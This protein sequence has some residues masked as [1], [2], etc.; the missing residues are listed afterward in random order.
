MPLLKTDAIGE[1]G[2]L[3]QRLCFAEQIG[4]DVDIDDLVGACSP[5]GDLADNDPGPASDFQH[6]L[7]RADAH[8]VQQVLTMVR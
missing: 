8:H 7:V 2:L 6:H 1:T 3:C 4:A 5:A